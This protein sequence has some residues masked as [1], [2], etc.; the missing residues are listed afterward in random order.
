MEK[1]NFLRS[2]YWY[3]APPPPLPSL[4]TAYTFA[5]KLFIFLPFLRQETAFYVPQSFRCVY[6]YH[7]TKCFEKEIVGARNVDWSSVAFKWNCIPGLFLKHITLKTIP[8]STT[9]S[10]HKQLK[11]SYIGLC[12]T[13][14]KLRY[15]NHTSSFRNERYRNAT[16]LRKHVW[17]LK[18]QNVQY[19]IKWRKIKQARSY[20]DVTKKCNLRLWGKKYFILCKPQMSLVFKQPKWACCRHFRKFLLKNVIT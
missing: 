16:E 6:S 10:L 3:K 15:R 5:Q 13:S 14:F 1:V 17:N 11:K 2:I 19:N 20:S 8:S 18:D 7:G 4:F 12:D 9:R